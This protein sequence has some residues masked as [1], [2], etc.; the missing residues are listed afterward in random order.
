M[1]VFFYIYY[2]HECHSYLLHLQFAFK[3]VWRNQGQHVI[4]YFFTC[5]VLYCTLLVFRL[6]PHNYT[7]LKSLI[8]VFEG[9]VYDLLNNIISA[10]IISQLIK[11]TVGN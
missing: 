9:C 10:D 8:S 2:D 7:F 5:Q 1:I 6:S 11:S 4:S 3:H